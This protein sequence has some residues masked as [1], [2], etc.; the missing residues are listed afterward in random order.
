[1]V[2][3]FSSMKDYTESCSTAFID[4]NF[5]L[6]PLILTGKIEFFMAIGSWGSPLF[7]YI[8]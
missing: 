1:M 4:G 2:K 8:N 5:F 6:Y 7:D 3:N